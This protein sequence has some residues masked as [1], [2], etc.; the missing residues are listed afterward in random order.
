LSLYPQPQHL[1]TST[2]VL[3][4][5]DITDQ[6]IHTLLHTSSIHS[7]TRNDTPIPIFQLPQFERLTDLACAF[8]ARLILLVG[9]DEE[10]SVAEFFFVE[11]GA[12]FFACG[13]Q[14]FDIGAVDDEY[15][16]GGVGVVAAPVR[17]D[18]G[19]ASEVLKWVLEG[20]NSW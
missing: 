7:T 20:R 13:G 9:K 11:H 14:T 3:P 15:Y 5:P 2:S 4:I 12:E 17:A 16:S 19:L 18:R 1:F 8:R 6:P 10:R